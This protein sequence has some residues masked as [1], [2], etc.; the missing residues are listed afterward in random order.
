MTL[1]KNF[2]PCHSY[3]K[4]R[5][6]VFAIIS[7]I[8]LILPF[9]R[10]DGNHLFLLNFDKSQL[11]LFF[12]KFDM[13]E[14]YLMPFLFIILFL[15]VFFVTTLA[16]RIWCGWS[17]PQ[18][19]FRVIFRDLLQ[20]KILKIN[21]SVQ[22]KQQAAK[23]QILKQISAIFIWAI[24][25]VLIASN[26]LWY[27]VPPEDFFAYLKD[28]SEH[29]ILIGFLA[30]IVLW[31]VYDVAILAEN[32][33]IYVC[34]YARVQ[35]VMFDSDTIQVIYNE[36]RGGKI[37]DKGVKLYKKP[38]DP[39]SQCTGCE[40]CVRICPTHIDIRKGMQL[41]CINCLECSDACAKVM[42]KFSLPSL[43]DWTSDN[44]QKTHRKVKF[45][46]FR[47]VAYL[48]IL[49]V[50]F[51]GLILMSGKKEHMLLNINRTS[52]LYSVGRD[53]SVENSYVFLFQNTDNK[54]HEYY[55]DTNDTNL[56]IVRPNSP[57]RIKAGAKQKTIVT[58]RSLNLNQNFKNDMP[59]SIMINAFA[60]DEQRKIN[61]NRETIFVY[62]KKIRYNNEFKN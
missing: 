57:V 32:F 41:E 13:Q 62:P 7:V 11:H 54:E 42:A 8:A 55:F 10:V 36:Q 29:K 6:I 31:L 18:T 30:C 56:K 4:R 58:L 46:R 61:V 35:S 39:E 16:G 23:G 17:C 5:Y 43:I 1:P 34:P 47:T 20:T 19:I 2:S 12:V 53:G 14:L 45:I 26:F 44:S 9:I 52:E 28:G 15:F 21:R 51:V 59:V 27:F 25:C 22:N 60:I 33:C 40:A 24:I 49:I 37:Y 3:T 50:A 48:V 38:P